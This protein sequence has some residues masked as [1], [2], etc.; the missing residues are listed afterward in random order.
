MN[1]SEV[2]KLSS[3]LCKFSPDGKYLVS[4]GDLGRGQDIL[5]ASVPGGQGRG[6][7]RGPGVEAARGSCRC[8]ARTGAGPGQVPGAGAGPE[9]VSQTGGGPRKIP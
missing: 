6:R 3:L 9:Q 7:P 5:G 8:G 1:F 4:G 2:F